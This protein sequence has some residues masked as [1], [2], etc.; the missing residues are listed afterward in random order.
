MSVV[1]VRAER[2]RAG[3][4][5]TA[6]CSICRSPKGTFAKGIPHP[7]RGYFKH[8]SQPDGLATAIRHVRLEH[9]TP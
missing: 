5:W 7:E 8:R 6:T 4:W 1:K 9:P 3:W 2:Y